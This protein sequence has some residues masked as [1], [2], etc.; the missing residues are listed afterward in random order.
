[1]RLVRNGHQRSHIHPAGWLSGVVYLKT[2]DLSDSEEGAI[3][4]GLHG[5]E[6]PILDDSYERKVHRPKAG[7]IL[8]FPSSLFHRTI[9]FSQDTDR[10]VIAFDM[11][12]AVRF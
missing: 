7:E 3:E 1:M 2:L 9:P 10:C 12:P 4:L 11:H 5:F 6:L 8:L